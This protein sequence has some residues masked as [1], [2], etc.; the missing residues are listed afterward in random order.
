[1]ERTAREMEDFLEDQHG[2]LKKIPHVLNVLPGTKVVGGANTEE[3]CITFY[4]DEKIEESLLRA[5]AE[6]IIPK[7]IG[8]YKTDVLELKAPDFRLGV[9]APSRLPPR[10]QK[11]MAGGVKK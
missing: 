10:I 1:M 3:P 11:R 5:K 7:F 8:K 6:E 9:T 4:V 2:S